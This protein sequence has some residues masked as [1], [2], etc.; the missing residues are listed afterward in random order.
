MRECIVP[1][2]Q[3]K[4]RLHLQKQPSK[5]H[6]FQTEYITLRDFAEAKFQDD[7]SID[8]FEGHMQISMITV[9]ARY[10]SDVPEFSAI[11]ASVLSCYG[12]LKLIPTS[13]IFHL[14][15]T[16]SARL[17]GRVY[18]HQLPGYEPWQGHGPVR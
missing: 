4:P 16:E 11:V 6:G 15:S 8:L 14:Q 10:D 1:Q 7:A 17:P 3:P 13:P 18:T 5:A 12:Q 2:L 9:P